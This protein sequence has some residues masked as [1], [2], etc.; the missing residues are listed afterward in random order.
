MPPTSLTVSIIVRLKSFNNE[1]AAPV[2]LLWLG[3][4]AGFHWVSVALTALLR[5]K[6]TLPPLPVES[7]LDSSLLLLLAFGLPALLGLFSVVEKA[8][9]FSER[10]R[11]NKQEFFERVWDE[12]SSAATHISFGTVAMWATTSPKEAPFPWG[13]VVYLAL[14]VFAFRHRPSPSEAVAAQRGTP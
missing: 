5:D 11:Q 7:F 4:G 9:R 14:A 6:I 8:M 2:F 3:I 10:E 13:M 1:R 12:I